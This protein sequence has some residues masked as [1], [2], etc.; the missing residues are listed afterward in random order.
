MV[1]RV[2]VSTYERYTI[3][4]RKYCDE[5]SFYEEYWQDPVYNNVDVNNDDVPDNP[6]KFCTINQF[7]QDKKIVLLYH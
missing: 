7:V 1:Y 2:G 4:H 6:T 5:A 3:P